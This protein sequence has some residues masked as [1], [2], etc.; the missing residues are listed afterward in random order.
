MVSILQPDPK[1]RGLFALRRVSSL[2]PLT[3]ARDI[4]ENRT[5]I[6]SEFRRNFTSGGTPIGG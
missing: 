2:P 3:V 5:G 1:V 6:A 4:C